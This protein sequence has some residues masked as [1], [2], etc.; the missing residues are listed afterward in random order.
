MKI[1]IFHN[2]YSGGAKRALYDNVSY[3]VKSHQ[4]DVFVPSTANETYL[5]LKDISN[6]FKTFPVKT[7]IHGCLFS[8]INYPPNKVSLRD[9]EI[10]EKSIANYI[11]KMDYDVVLCEQ[12]FF[13]IAPF[14]LKYIKK[15][16][17][18]YCQ[19]SP[20]YRYHLFRNI[21]SNLGFEYKNLMKDPF[22]K[23]YRG[24]INKI[25]HKNIQSANYI[26]ANSF[27]SR[28]SLLHVYGINSFVSYLGVD[29]KLFK[30]LNIPKE[31]FV[32]TVGRCIPEKGYD[33]ILRSLA[34]IDS[35]IRP[36]FVIVS[37]Y[38][39]KKWKKYL[40]ETAVKYDVKLQIMNL[41]NDQD[42]VLLYNKALLIVYAPYL[43]PFGLVPLEAMAC[44]TPV[45][46]VKEGGVRETVVNNM[47]GILTE[48]D[49][50]QFA[51]KIFDL[52]SDDKKMNLMSQKSIKCIENFWNLEESGKRLEYHLKRA[53]DIYRM[54]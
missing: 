3:L 49:E 4:V 44:G 16:T 5:P 22:L 23:Y 30:P 42:L 17:V 7:T 45:V 50:S 39:D 19:Q 13:S 36:E 54:V 33:F 8:V 6:K 37:D 12:E 26:L 53:S 47:T 51:E 9:L 2:L 10:V 11:N 41:I 31:N 27:F 32:L 15:P 34:K 14:F 38:A 18:Y 48:R 20:F 40:E 1:A 21:R 43:E 28:E 29:N 46:A 24:R 25:D 35:K 52:L